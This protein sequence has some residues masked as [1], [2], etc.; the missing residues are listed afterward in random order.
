MTYADDLDVDQIYIEPPDTGIITDEDS[1]NEDE[2]GLVDNLSGPQ[3]NTTA[4]LYVR[5]PHSDD[6][7]S[8][9]ESMDNVEKVDYSNIKWIKGDLEEGPKISLIQIIKC[10]KLCH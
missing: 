2:G 9:D 5:D 7:G 3:L 1:G 6:F 4:E 10:L 8:V